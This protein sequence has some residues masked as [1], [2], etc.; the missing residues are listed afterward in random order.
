MPFNINLNC[1]MLFCGDLVLG[2]GYPGWR[3]LFV[4]VLQLEKCFVFL[5]SVKCQLNC[6]SLLREKKIVSIRF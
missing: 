6:I 4:L 3:I 2:L 5:A 1:K